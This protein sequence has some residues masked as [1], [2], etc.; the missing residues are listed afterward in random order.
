M[1]FYGKRME[2]AAIGLEE[3][4][5]VDEARD[6]LKQSPKPEAMSTETY[7][8]WLAVAAFLVRR[9]RPPYRYEYR[10]PSSP[11]G[12]AEDHGYL[13][14]DSRGIR[15]LA[16]GSSLAPVR[17]YIGD[18]GEKPPPSRRLRIHLVVER[19]WFAFT[20][21]PKAKDEPVP[22]V[23]ERV[24]VET[25]L[26]E[27]LVAAFGVDVANKILGIRTAPSRATTQRRQRRQKAWD[28][29]QVLRSQATSLQ[30]RLR[31]LLPRGEDLGPYEAQVSLTVQQTPP[32]DVGD[33]QG[34]VSAAQLLMALATA[35]LHTADAERATA[36]A[37]A[38][39]A[40][41]RRRQEEAAEQEENV[42]QQELR[43]TKRRELHTEALRL[44]GDVSGSSVPRDQWPPVVPALWQAIPGDDVRGQ[45]TQEQLDRFEAAVNAAREA[46]NQLL[47]DIL[48]RKFGGTRQSAKKQHRRKK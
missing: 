31:H 46:W 6:I 24:L 30:A 42:R 15:G 40:E 29:L 33:L 27:A 39:L 14:E 38:R 12:D 4:R 41:Q 45:T 47:T 1:K 10:K 13:L 37:E 32:S 3:R 19:P 25:A 18:L 48:L 8:A 22:F 7:G 17:L 35:Q 21:G 43:E 20:G 44:L 2:S 16:E 23:R 34:W 11:Q 5:D 26:R 36:V 9:I 28:E